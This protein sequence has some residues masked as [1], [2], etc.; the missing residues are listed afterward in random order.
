MSRVA[1]LG[2]FIVAAS[3]CSRAAECAKRNTANLAN[4][5]MADVLS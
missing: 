3:V 2:A 1:R 5:E 4:E